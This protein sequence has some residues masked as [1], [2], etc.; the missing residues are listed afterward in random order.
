MLSAFST[1][2]DNFHALSIEIYGSYPIICMPKF[3]AARA[4]KDPIAPKPIM[5]SVFAK[6]SLP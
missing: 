6:T 1:S 3:L 5:P 4:T 2:D